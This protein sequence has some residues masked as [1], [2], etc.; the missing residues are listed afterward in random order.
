MIESN[1]AFAQAVAHVPVVKPVFIFSFGLSS[2]DMRWFQLSCV[3]I[4]DVIS[5]WLI[6]LSIEPLLQVLHKV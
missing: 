1:A 3:L 6:K 4:L 2:S 5:V